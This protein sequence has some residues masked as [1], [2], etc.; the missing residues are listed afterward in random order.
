MSA[1]LPHC[2]LWQAT[3]GE[4]RKR[5]RKKEG[6]M[7]TAYTQTHGIQT[8]IKFVIIGQMDSETDI[9]MHKTNDYMFIQYVINLGKSCSHQ[10]L[11]DS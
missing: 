2:L 5:E 4:E 1:L 8:Q 9:Y 6:K 3:R 10:Q 11:K 7:E